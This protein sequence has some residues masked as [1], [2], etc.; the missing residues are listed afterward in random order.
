MKILSYK[1]SLLAAAVTLAATTLVGTA[2]SVNPS[3]ASEKAVAIGAANAPLQGRLELT[4]GDAKP[5]SKATH[6][7]SVT[8]VDDAGRRHAF[9][10]DSALKAAGDLYS[11]NN[12]RVAVTL[13]PQ[14]TALAKAAAAS[15]LS[16]PE[17]IV[18]IDD[19]VSNSVTGKAG[20]ISTRVVTTTWA[21]VMCKFKDIATEQKPRSFFQAQYGTAAGE[22]GQYWSLVSYGNIN[23]NGSTAYGWFTLPQNRSFYV[24]SAGANLDKL[25][26]DCTAA[27]NASV[28]FAANG[29]LQGI[30]MMFNGDL[31]GYAWGGGRCATLDG[32]NKCWSSTWNPPWAF[33]NLAPLAHE[34]GH[35]YG[36]PHANNSDG[37]SDTYDNPWDVMSDAYSNANT[38]TTYGTLP[39]NL[40]VYSRNRLGYLTAARKRTINHSTTSQ[41]F[42]LAYADLF[43]GDKTRMVTLVIPGTTTRYYTIEARGRRGTYDGNLAGNAVIIHSV[44]TAR[45][46]PAWSVDAA[47]PKAD[48]SNNEGSMFKVGESWST[49]EASGKK[50]RVQVI[51]ATTEGFTIDV[52]GQ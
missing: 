23:L 31:D 24:T 41:R 26:D 6:R 9:D 34:M 15:G 25:F 1:I 18:P 51:N 16:V 52:V 14:T 36:L 32:I 46:S 35:A 45:A 11:L 30:N 48:V 38:S 42:E 8:L 19:L 10:S 37:D 43:S 47:S 17:V 4:W 50:F 29:G 13:V 49:P 21:T 28:N 33:Q 27:A 22:L 39:K 7:F 40:N 20:D 12:S 2:N 44:D 5:G 3:S